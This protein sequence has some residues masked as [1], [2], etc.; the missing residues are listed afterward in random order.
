M[1]KQKVTAVSDAELEK[2]GPKVFEKSGPKKTRKLNSSAEGR[3]ANED[4]YGFVEAE[5]LNLFSIEFYLGKN[6]KGREGNFIYLQGKAVLYISKAQKQRFIQIKPSES[7]IINSIPSHPIS[8]YSIL[9]YSS[10]PLFP[11][12]I[13]FRSAR[14]IPPSGKLASG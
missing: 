11:V 4:L 9:F 3:S 12:E 8:F 7:L 14:K 5:I 6:L 13:S 2:S 1:K 10:T